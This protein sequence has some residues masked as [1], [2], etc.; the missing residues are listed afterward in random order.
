M[1]GGFS[2]HFSACK[3]F[4]ERILLFAV[5]INI[6]EG[7]GDRSV[8]CLLIFCN[9]WD[10]IFEYPCGTVTCPVLSNDR[11]TEW[12]FCFG[13]GHKTLFFLIVILLYIYNNITINIFPKKMDARISNCHSVILSFTVAITELQNDSFIFHSYPWCVFHLT[14]TDLQLRDNWCAKFC[15]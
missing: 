6:D 14:S 12:Q 9:I 3:Y 2:R 15:Q 13:R 11:M 8:S 1:F 4:K 7:T 10:Y 5:G